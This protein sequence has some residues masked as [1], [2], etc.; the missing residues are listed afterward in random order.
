MNLSATILEYSL[1]PFLKSSRSAE[2]FELSF[3]TEYFIFFDS[4]LLTWL[5]NSGSRN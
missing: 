2:E 1:H 3:C 4:P 5:L